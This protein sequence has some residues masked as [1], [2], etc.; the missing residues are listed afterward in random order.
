VKLLP[1]S[2]FQVSTYETQKRES[3]QVIFLKCHSVGWDWVHLVRRQ[4]TGVL[5]QSRMMMNVEHL[6]EWEL[7]REAEVLEENLPQCH[8]VHRTGDRTRG[9]EVGSRRLI[10][11]VMVRPIT[12]SDNPPFFL[13]QRQLLR[14]MKRSL[15]HSLTHSLMELNPSWK[16]A[17]CAA[18][19]ELPSILWNPK[20]HYR[21]H[22]SPPLI[23]IPSQINPI[24]TIPSYLSNTYFNIVHP[25]LRLGLPSGLL[26]SGFPTSILHAF[27]FSP[28][29]LHA[30]PISSSF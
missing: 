25:P 16:A 27:L 29:V 7:A 17:N 10:A 5:H 26:P 8:F 9:T 18:T 13:K 23:P 14:M 22:K 20:V 30:L 15:T 28:F 2:H 3:L 4:I 6:V 1:D 11:W 24:H 12:T 21:I 19:Q